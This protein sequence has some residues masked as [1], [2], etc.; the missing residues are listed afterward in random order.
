MKQIFTINK[1]NI[2]QKS[3]YEQYFH[4]F[5]ACILVP[6]EFWFSYQQNMVTILI[7]TT[8]RNGSLLE[9][10]SLLEGLPYITVDTQKCDAYFHLGAYQRKYSIKIQ[11]FNSFFNKQMFF[12]VINKCQTVILRF[13][14][15]LHLC[16]FSLSG[17]AF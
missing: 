7:S 15:P 9:G 2:M 13:A 11:H 14:P 12:K 4:C 10:R 5:I 1:L 6:Y 17:R 16:D 8:F 3:K